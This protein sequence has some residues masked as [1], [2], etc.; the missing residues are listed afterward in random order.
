MER[1]GGINLSELVDKMGLIHLLRG[2]AVAEGGHP[3]QSLAC[4]RCSG[5]SNS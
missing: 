4:S 5:H 1:T 3:A 2:E